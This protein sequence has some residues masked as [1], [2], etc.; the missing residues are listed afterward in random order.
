MGVKEEKVLIAG[1][2]RVGICGSTGRMITGSCSAAGGITAGVKLSG[3]ESESTISKYA[4]I[5]H[6]ERH[7]TVFHPH[8]SEPPGPIGTVAECGC[9]DRGRELG[10]VRVARICD[11]SNSS[12]EGYVWAYNFVDQGEEKRR[13][14]LSQ[15]QLHPP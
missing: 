14:R 7:A 1:S 4:K 8:V 13:G 6:S 12:T 15:G 9:R 10:G 11:M 2:G 5:G 3:G